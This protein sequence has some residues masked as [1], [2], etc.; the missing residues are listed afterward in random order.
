MNKLIVGFITLYFF[1]ATVFAENSLPLRDPFIAIDPII[2]NAVIS[3]V[4]HSCWIP[5][6]FSKAENIGD[7]ISKKSL[8]ILSDDGELNVDPHSN[9]LWVQDDSSHIAQIKALVHHLDQPGPQ[10][11]IK[12]KIINLDRDYQ[13]ALGFLF[14]TETKSTA[15]IIGLSMDQPNTNE[16]AGEFTLS[17]ARFADNHLLDMQISA[18]EQEGHASLISSPSL[19]TLNNATALIESG[20]EVP[21]QE[22]TLSGGT[23]VSFKKAVLRLEVTP[24]KMPNNHILL[25][26]SLN[27]DKVS[28]L[29][30]KGVPAIQTQQITTQVIVKTNQTIVLGGILETE[31]ATQTQGI[32]VL[33]AIPVMG[34]L[35]QHATKSRQQREL[36]IFITPSMMKVY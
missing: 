14:Q 15:P 26:I 3:Q 11:L 25:H 4:Q 29:T 27:Q 19:T 32:P 31:K 1:T 10:F 17:I 28:A 36:L 2:P 7:F 24:Q 33:S 34:K 8:H 18:L 9:Q 30:V 22:A 12:A 21:Y 16:N 35:F 6:Y 5:I 20:A 23:S 13:N